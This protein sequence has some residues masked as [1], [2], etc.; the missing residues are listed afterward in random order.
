MVPLA[1]DDV[2]LP[3]APTNAWPARLAHG[4]GEGVDRELLDSVIEEQFDPA[5]HRVRPLSSHF[6]LHRL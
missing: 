4:D 2:S 6:N 1:S 5:K 3:P